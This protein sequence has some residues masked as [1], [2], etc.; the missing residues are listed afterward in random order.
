MKNEYDA[1]GRRKRMTVAGQG[2]L[3]RILLM[4]GIIARKSAANIKLFI[5]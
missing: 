2:H 5:F 4:Q 1:I 3:Q